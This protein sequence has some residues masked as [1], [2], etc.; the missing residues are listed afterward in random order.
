MV[1][2]FQIHITLQPLPGTS[3]EFSVVYIDNAPPNVHYSR[4]GI[5]MLWSA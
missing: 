5:H 1:G 3:C 2:M 4:I